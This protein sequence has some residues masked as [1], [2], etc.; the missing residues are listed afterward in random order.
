M[1]PDDVRNWLAGREGDAWVIRLDGKPVG[2]IEVAS[3][4][5]S[6]GVSV[7]A[8]TVEREVWLLPEARGKRVSTEATRLLAPHLRAR[9]VENVLDVIWET[10]APALRAAARG[11]FE[12]IGRGWWEHEGEAPGWCE[13]WLLRLP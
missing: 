11:G 1:G 3:V 13:V 9:G 7:P 4:R 10:N 2:W 5:D 12:R 8:G 6:C